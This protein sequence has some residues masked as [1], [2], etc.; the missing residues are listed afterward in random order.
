MLDSSARLLHLL[1]LLQARRDWS[2]ADLADRLQITPRTVRR[3]VDRLRALGYTVEATPGVGGGY[4][5]GFG[6]GI[7]P[8]LLD[9]DEAV[10]VAV[11]LRSTAGGVAGAAEASVRALMKLEP[12]LPAGLGAGCSCSRRFCCRWPGPARR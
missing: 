11:A 12:S 10:A 5:L 4:R 3:D 9:E 8:L 2:S 6:T 1:A 7:P